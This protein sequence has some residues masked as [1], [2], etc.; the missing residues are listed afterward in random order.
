MPAA[1]QERKPRGIMELVQSVADLFLHLD[2][3]LADLLTRYGDWTYLLL[4]LI[5]F[6][7][8]G[9]VVT[10]FLPGDSLLFA[11]GALA[12]REV[13]LSVHVLFVLL[14]AAAIIGY[15]T[16]YWIG[17]MFGRR[18]LAR[19]SRWISAKQIER[20]HAFFEKYGGKTIVLAR[21]VPILR[22]FP[23]FVAGLGSMT[24]PRFMMFNVTGGIAWVGICLYAGYFF[25][26]IP[27]VQEHFELVILGIIVVSFVPAVVEVWKHRAAARASSAES[28]A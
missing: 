17:H 5:I 13:G 26:Q 27:V 14:T 18:L 1:P 6:A 20:T 3:H 11:A 23:P 15:T 28:D 4:F 19:E 12:A 21:F 9:L 7:E 25:G 22:T 16:N 8:T 10:P 2:T 24:Y